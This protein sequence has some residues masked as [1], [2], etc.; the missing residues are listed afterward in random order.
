MRINLINQIVSWMPLL[1][2]AGS[3]FGWIFKNIWKKIKNLII[4]IH[5]A[6]T[7]IDKIE[8]NVKDIRNELTMFINTIQDTFSEKIISIQTTMNAQFERM[9][10]SIEKIY[11]LMINGKDKEH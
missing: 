6:H 5:N 4:K 9:S 8:E 1:V 3:F 2:I 10:N 7:R 11:V